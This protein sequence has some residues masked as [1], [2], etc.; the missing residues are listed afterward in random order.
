MS[1]GMCFLC[2]SL[3]Q[4]R[5][6]LN[7]Y[8]LIYRVAK[9]FPPFW[10]WVSVLHIYSPNVYMWEKGHVL[11][12]TAFAVSGKACLRHYVGCYVG[13][14][15]T[16]CALKNKFTDSVLCVAIVKNRN[17]SERNSSGLTKHYIFSFH[18]FPTRSMKHDYFPFSR[19]KGKFFF[20][21]KWQ[22]EG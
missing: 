3:I 18:R 17:W 4:S 21:H 15:L 6:C 19:W 10:L 12:S 9:I 8:L 5:Q 11:K 13:L 22:D 16:N 14:C 2:C 20:W 7:F 1:P